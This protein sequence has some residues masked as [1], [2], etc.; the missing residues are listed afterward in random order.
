MKY[1]IFGIG[2][3]RTG[4]TSLTN[5]LNKVGYNI[6]H[7]PKTE[8][9]IFSNANDGCTDIPVILYY[10]ELY[11]FFP[12]IKFVY[13]IR[14]KEKWLDSIVPYFERKR[15]WKRIIGARQEELRTK[16]YGQSFPNRQ[17]ASAAW[18][19]HHNDVMEFFIDKQDKL[20]VLDITG[21]DNTDKLWKFLDMN[22]DNLPKKFPH[23]NKLIK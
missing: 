14:N 12:N 21:G 5:I 13:T 6:I 17:Q 3:S 7:Y 16:V 8:I 23:D 19:R 10:K 15:S 20:L 18:D 2:L 9:Q 22:D 4:T 11:K 1:K